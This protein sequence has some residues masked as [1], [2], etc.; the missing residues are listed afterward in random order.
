MLPRMAHLSIDAWRRPAHRSDLGIFRVAL[1]QQVVAGHAHCFQSDAPKQALHM[2]RP[3]RTRGST[4]EESNTEPQS[5]AKTTKADLY[6]LTQF[7]LADMVRCGAALRSLAIDCG[8]MEEAAQKITRYLYEA[9]KSRASDTR[10]CVL[11]RFFRTHRYER[12]SD[13]LQTAGRSAV[14]SPV[15]GDMK[16]LVLLGTC[17]DEP[18]WNARRESKGHRCIPL[19]S[20]SVIA[21]FPMISRLIQ[22]LGVPVSA[23]LRPAPQI[24]KDFERKSFGVFY[25]PAA[26]G[27][28]F[29]PA[30]Q[31]FVVPHRVQSVL[32]FGGIQPDGELFVV[33][34]FARVTIPP[35]TAEMFRTIALSLK[36]GMLGLIDKPVFAD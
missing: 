3:K 19:Q 31:D 34:A 5:P 6:D 7:T 18:R 35:S 14:S 20:E 13:E 33:I 4:D 11:V 22:Q 36:L 16:C 28:P 10:S 17:G 30:Q 32:G 12:L 27:S 15:A 29:V 1:S 8:S 9:L 23:L 2:L 21:Q 26:A 25:V 24:I